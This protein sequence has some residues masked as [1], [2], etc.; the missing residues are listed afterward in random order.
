MTAIDQTID[1]RGVHGLE[2][3][4]VEKYNRR[5]AHVALCFRLIAGNRSIIVTGTRK[6]EA[7][8][9]EVSDARIDGFTIGSCRCGVSSGVS[10]GAE[11]DIEAPRHL[12]DRRRGR[13]CDAVCLA[14]R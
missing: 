3:K 10:A 12:C 13:Q 9:M 6:T 11:P 4:G 1:I 14:F 5:F 2:E 8:L 7:K